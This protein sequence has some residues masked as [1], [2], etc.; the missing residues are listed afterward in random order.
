MG[1][2]SREPDWD[3]EPEAIKLGEKSTE[4]FANQGHCVLDYKKC[5]SYFTL[6]EHIKPEDVPTETYSHH[7]VPSENSKK[8]QAKGSKQAKKEEL[9]NPQTR[10]FD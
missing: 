6:S 8:K 3:K 1:N 5:G 9:A 10:M 2:C 4:G 7:L